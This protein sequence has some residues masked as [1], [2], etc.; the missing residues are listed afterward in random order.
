[1]TRRPRH[2]DVVHRDGAAGNASMPSPTTSSSIC[3]D[4]GGAVSGMVTL[5]LPWTDPRSDSAAPVT[6]GR[7]AGRSIGG[8][9]TVGT[10]RMVDHLVTGAS[11]HEVG[12]STD[13]ARAHHDERGALLLGGVQQD[14]GG[15]PSTSRHATCRRMAASSGAP[16]GGDALDLVAMFAG[17]HLTPSRWS[18]TRAR[19]PP[20]RRH[21]SRPPSWRDAQGTIGVLG[22]VD[23]ARRSGRPTSR[24]RQSVYRSCQLPELAGGG[25][26]GQTD[27][28]GRHGFG[29]VVGADE[30]TER[31]AD[32]T[33][34]R[35]RRVSTL[36]H[37]ERHP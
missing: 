10:V 15:L 9:T 30:R 33:G 24:E 23:A 17:R 32:R 20:P 2:T 27:L 5:G 11:E 13:A 22:P 29:P 12:M 14:V 21:R 6:A 4:S 34:E 1:M 19:G 7:V 8:T 16:V 35:L 25:D 37:H 18:S 26:G 3:S 31:G 36:E 28:A